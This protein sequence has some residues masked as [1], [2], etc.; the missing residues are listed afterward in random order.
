MP[1][2]KKSINKPSDKNL[3]RWLIV[4]VF[5]WVIPS[6]LFWSSLYLFLSEIC[7]RK[8]TNSLN[9]LENHLEN[10]AYDSSRERFF[11]KNLSIQKNCYG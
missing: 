6:V 11:Q 3:I 10:I 7:E 8:D 2:Y 9:E 1:E 4:I 5:V